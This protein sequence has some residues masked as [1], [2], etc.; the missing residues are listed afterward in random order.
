MTNKIYAL[1]D[2]QFVK[3][4]KESCNISEVLFKL[5]YS[6]QGNSWGFSLIRKRM[7]ELKLTHNSFK[8]KST[9]RK[10]VE[11]IIDPNKLFK[12]NSYI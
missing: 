9:L 3:L 7:D 10:H 11:R 5:G 8:G 4:I 12:E 2:E 1:T 6:I